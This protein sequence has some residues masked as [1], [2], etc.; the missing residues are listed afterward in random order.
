MLLHAL[1]IELNC[2]VGRVN[3]G[4]RRLTGQEGGGH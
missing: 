3:S 4:V 1:N 2:I